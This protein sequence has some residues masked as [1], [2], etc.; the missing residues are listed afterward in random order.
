MRASFSKVTYA[1]TA[2]LVGLDPDNRLGDIETFEIHR[3]RIPT[4][5]FRSIVT[6]MDIMLMEYGPPPEHQSEEARSRFF[7]PVQII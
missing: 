3:S 4:H 1:Q 5:L 6:D 7:S 2:P